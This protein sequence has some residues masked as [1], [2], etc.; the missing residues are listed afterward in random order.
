MWCPVLGTSWR[1]THGVRP[2]LENERREAKK[3]TGSRRGNRRSAV[4]T[5]LW[6]M[7]SV[8]PKSEKGNNR[9]SSHR[10][11]KGHNIFSIGVVR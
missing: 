10:A 4:T 6:R 3:G 9:Q 7:F 5:H 11:L 8:C 1:S 2:C